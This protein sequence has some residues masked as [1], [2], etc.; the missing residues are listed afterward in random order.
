MPMRDA[1]HAC[2]LSSFAT[3]INF[4][5]GRKPSQKNLYKITKPCPN[6]YPNDVLMLKV[7]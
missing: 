6:I 4:V 3:Y 2:K 1:I 5:E 7:T